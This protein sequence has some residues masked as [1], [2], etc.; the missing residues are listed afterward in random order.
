MND[1]RIVI[2]FPQTPRGSATPWAYGS[3]RAVARLYVGPFSTIV[4]ST[5]RLLTWKSGN[6]S[7]QA[8]KI[9]NR[10]SKEWE[11][12]ELTPK[13]AFEL[14][15]DNVPGSR[16]VKLALIDLIYNED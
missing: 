5:E 8:E 4:D 9:I 2:D 6:W 12:V 14:V 3:F 11:G 13:E 1:I 16:Q 7:S 15:P 10:F